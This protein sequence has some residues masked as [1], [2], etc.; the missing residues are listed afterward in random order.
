MARQT[1]IICKNI[2][3]SGGTVSKEAFTQKWIELINQKEKNKG[4]AAA[5]G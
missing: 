5:S 3:K 1:R 2:F 4:R